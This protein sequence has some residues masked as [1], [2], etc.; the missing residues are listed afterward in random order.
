[1]KKLITGLNKGLIMGKFVEI[2]QYRPHVT[3]PT[4]N[5][6]YIVPEQVLRDIISGELE[7]TEWEGYR[8]LIPTIIEDWLE[9]MQPVTM[10]D[11][12]T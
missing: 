9:R 12:P 1:M 10:A 6:V 8:D 7:I 5:G 2:D 4:D 11:K 3:I